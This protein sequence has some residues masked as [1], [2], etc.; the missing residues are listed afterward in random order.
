MHH[1]IYASILEANNIVITSHK[2]PD[3]DSIGSSMALY[4]F[5]KRLE[6]TVDVV[7]PDPYPNFLSWIKDVG[8][9]INYENQLELATD[10]IQKADLIFCLDYNTA[11]RVGPM[12]EILE[13]SAG[14]KIMIDHHLNPSD[15]AEIV[16]SKPEISSTAELIFEF[17][18]EVRPEM[19]DT[20][21]GTPIYLGMMTDTG[22]FR[23]PSVTS[24]THEVLAKLLASGVVH[25]HVHEQVFDQVSLSQL[26][27]KSYA[28]NQKLEMIENNQVALIS[29]SLEE[30]NMYSYEKGD[31]EGL[32]NMALAIKGVKMAVF[33]KEAEGLLKIS[34][35]SKHNVHVNQFAADYFEGGGHKY[36]AGGASFVDMEKTLEK[37]KTH[38]AEYL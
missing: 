34:F 2:S 30:L 22:S 32:I 36:A 16:L 15:L 4:Q 24:R 6:K 20:N 26:K 14:K 1:Q 12:A 21:T 18:N 25:N 5:I 19:I 28:I 7:H 3:G 10:K 27:L 17:I 38:V 13:S 11:G 8:D 37:I 23:F 33:V 31:T 29:L 35:R 9:I